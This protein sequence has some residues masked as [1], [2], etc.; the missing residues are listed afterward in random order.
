MFTQAEMHCLRLVSDSYIKRMLS[1]PPQA[2]AKA[3]LVRETN[4][5][6]IVGFDAFLVQIYLLDFAKQFHAT[7]LYTKNP[8]TMGELF[9]V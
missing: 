8:P 5:V 1:T 6:G 2:V 4:R 9:Y 7:T 3:I